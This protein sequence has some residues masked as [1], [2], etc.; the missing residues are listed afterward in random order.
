MSKSTII[1]IVI[2][3]WLMGLFLLI[4]QP[5]L[6][7]DFNEGA[8]IFEV[9]CAGCHPSGNNI[10]R[11]T[12][13]LKLKALQRNKLDSIEGITKIVTYGKNNMSAY[14][15]RLTSEEINAVASY[16][17]SQAENNWSK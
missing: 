9:Q 13:T 14:Q 10:I 16:V 3:G 12:K 1:L 6:A 11:R 5:A 2:I 7:A 17:L 4:D 15:D 8:K